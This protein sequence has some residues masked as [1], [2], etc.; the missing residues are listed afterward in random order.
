MTVH[1][2]QL[3]TYPFLACRH[4]N[5]HLPG[6]VI[7]GGAEMGLSQRGVSGLLPDSRANRLAE[8][9]EHQAQPAL[10]SLA[11]NRTNTQGKSD[12]STNEERGSTGQGSCRPR[13]P[14]LPSPAPRSWEAHDPSAS[15]P[16]RWF[17]TPVAGLSLNHN[18][19]TGLDAIGQFHAPQEITISRDRTTTPTQSLP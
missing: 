15:D 17:V 9:G 13:E 5:G 18:H 4:L 16:G 6:H 8:R 12:A 7:G 2:K 1:S 3:H 19:G 11:V 10:A 14:P